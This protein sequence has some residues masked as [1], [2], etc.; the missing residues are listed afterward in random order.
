MKFQ[1]KINQ[2]VALFEAKVLEAK[3]FKDAIKKA[4]S[5]YHF[6]EINIEYSING[7]QFSVENVENGIVV[8]AYQGGT[9]H[10]TRIFDQNA[11][12]NHIFNYCNKFATNHI[13]RRQRITGVLK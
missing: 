4:V 13:Y 12:E 11:H 2:L 1:E 7:F 5:Q 3:A 10:F 6:F 8:T 9:K